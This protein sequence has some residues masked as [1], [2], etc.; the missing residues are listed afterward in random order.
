MKSC[1]T[2]QEGFMVNQLSVKCSVLLMASGGLPTPI[3]VMRTLPVQVLH[4]EQGTVRQ[5]TSLS[6]S[7]RV[8][9]FQTKKCTL[10]V[11]ETRKEKMDTIM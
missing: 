9:V 8:A 10:N 3:E 7:L 11:W 2:K 6:F 4:L 5:D 1:C